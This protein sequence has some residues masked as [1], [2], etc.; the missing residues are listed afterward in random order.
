MIYKTESIDDVA[1]ALFSG[2]LL[3]GALSCHTGNL[4]TLGPSCHEEAKPHAGALVSSPSLHV[5]PE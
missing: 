4:I 1:F 2:A 5:I 3:F